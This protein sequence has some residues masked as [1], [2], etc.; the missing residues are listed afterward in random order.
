MTNLER[1]AAHDKAQ[2]AATTAFVE[3]NGRPPRHGDKLNLSGR[4][5]FYVGDSYRWH[6]VVDDNEQQ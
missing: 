3:V 4:H 1:F 2:D 5:L 6:L